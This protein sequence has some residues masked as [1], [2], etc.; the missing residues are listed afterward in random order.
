MHRQA[1]L[2]VPERNP[3]SVCT[4][5]RKTA[6]ICENKKHSPGGTLMAG[7]G[8]IHDKLEIKFLILYIT[9]RV[10]EPIPFDTVLDL[11]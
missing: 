11:T 3:N 6:I 10:I 9:A 1:V 4:K 8:F 5:S 2:F 7:H